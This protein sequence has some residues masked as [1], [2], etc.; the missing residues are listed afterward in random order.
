MRAVVSIAAAKKSIAIA[1][2]RVESYNRVRFIL[3]LPDVLASDLSALFDNPLHDGQFVVRLGH[4]QLRPVQLDLLLK[5]N[6]CKK[7]PAQNAGFL[8]L[9]MG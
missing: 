9:R 6:F 1:V 3:C 5:L 7:R 8:P 2:G 4:I